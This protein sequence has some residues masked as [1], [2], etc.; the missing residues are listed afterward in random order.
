M[1]ITPA[2]TIELERVTSNALEPSTAFDGMT[3]ED[4]QATIYGWLSQTDPLILGLG[5]VDELINAALPRTQFVKGL[6]QGACLLDLGAGDGSLTIYKS[7][8]RP[9]RSDLKIYGLSLVP[10]DREAHYHAVAY[11]DFEGTTPVF[12]GVQF[13]AVVCAH[14][15]EHMH[16]PRRVIEFFSSRLRPGGAAYIEWPHQLSKRFP[17]RWDFIG[18][19]LPTSTMNFADDTTHVETWGM[20]D[21]AEIA[22]S[23]GLAVESSGR[24]RSPYLA[25]HLRDAA[26]RTSDVTRLTL[27]IW[28]NFGWAQYLVARKI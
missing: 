25:G 27:S 6:P 21:I 3:A 16:D 26:K 15:I 5:E 18:R 12:D 17:P 23:C 20:A 1:S 19:G 13:D 24:V 14:F 28:W 22:L 10:I 11:S 7:W 4:L 8:P 2:S 9:D